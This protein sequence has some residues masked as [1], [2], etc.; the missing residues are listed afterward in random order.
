M[1]KIKLHNVL[2]FMLLSLIVTP[3]YAQQQPAFNHYMFNHQSVNPAYVGSKTY[4][5]L[6]TVYRSQWAGFEGAPI[7]QTISL[8]K[9]ISSKNLGIGFSVINDKIGPIKSTAVDIDIA[10]HLKLN[11]NEN[12]LS[13]GLK[14]GGFNYNLNE[15]LIQT[16]DPFD[17]TFLSEDQ[18][19]F[20]PNIGFGL[21]YYSQKIYAGIA[22]PRI[23]E[24]AEID[25]KKH[26]Y[27]ISG[28]L[29]T[30]SAQWMIKPSL[31]IKQSQGSSL[32]YDLSSLLIYKETFW[33]GAQMR[34]SMNSLLPEGPM[35]GSYS[36]LTGF[37][38]NN[39]LSLGYSY[40]FSSSRN[41]TLNLSTHEIMLRY[42]IL[43]KVMGLLRSPRFF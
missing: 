30:A 28:G 39:N 23:I 2:Y 18:K 31:L 27:F 5:S 6:T 10:Y 42:D 9:P 24:N 19:N 36:F 29:I 38:I 3:F 16:N 20:Y 15:D 34:S 25:S 22:I 13:L 33:I 8:N 4:T 40:G 21:Y 37:T 43:P 11:R 12:F 17:Q 32:V 1:R 14:F 41:N 35:A 26:F 7:T